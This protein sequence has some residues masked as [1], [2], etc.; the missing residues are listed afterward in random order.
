MENV[1]DLSFDFLKGFLIILVITGH[2]LPG[3]ADEGF[4]GLI[5]YFH[6]PLFMATTGYF[7]KEKNL[8]QTTAILLKKYNKRLLIPYAIAF[9]AY[10]C[11]YLYFSIGINQIHIKHIIGSV[12][13]PLY[14]LWYIPAILFFILY[15][16]I[17]SNSK[18]LTLIAFIATT[19]VSIVWYAYSENL[20]NSFPLIKYMGDKRFYYYYSFFLIGYILGNNTIKIKL[21]ISLTL[22]LALALLNYILELTP[23]INSIVWYLFNFSLI[24]L[25]IRTCQEVSIINQNLITKLGQTSLPV[26]LW[27]VAII[28]VTADFID[29]RKPLYYIAVILLVSV[30]SLLFIYAHNRNPLLNKLFYGEVVK[31]DKKT[32]N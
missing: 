28:T 8:K 2:I 10:T 23:L 3:N 19:T 9:L 7:I 26:Y 14:H 20:T 6:M 18:K 16:K 27:H 30:L 31:V 1:R 22:C 21:G 15:T 25:I 17:I 11:F 32:I 4:R 29:P 12:I 5:Y 24:N 13:Y